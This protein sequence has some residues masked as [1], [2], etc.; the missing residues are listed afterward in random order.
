M[1]RKRAD[2]GPSKPLDLACREK[3]A[4][5]PASTRPRPTRDGRRLGAR[6][7]ESCASLLTSRE[8]G[9]RAKE[10]GEKGD[11]GGG[12]RAGWPA[13]VGTPRQQRVDEGV[14]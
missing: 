3:H 4:T 9:R 13:D 7:G 14:E 8:G 12:T 1:V 5:P 11:E 2:G 10:I 6:V